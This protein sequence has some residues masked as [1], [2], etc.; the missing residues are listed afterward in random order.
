MPGIVVT[1]SQ[2]AKFLPDPD[3]IRQFEKLLAAVDSL[4]ETIDDRVALLIQDGTGISWVYDDSADT[5][6]PT[7]TLA[8][9]STTDLSE[10]TNLYYTEARV[11]ANTDVTANTSHRGSTSNP[12]SV[13]KAQVGLGNV[14]NT[15]DANKPVST[16]QQ[17][18]LDLKANIASPS[19]TGTAKTE[20]DTFG[21]DTAKT[22]SSASD[23]GTTGQIAWDSTYFYICVATDTWQ[24][25][26]H[27]TW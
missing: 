17:T 16:T 2:L 9:F 25:V 15:S 12:H 24:R 26:A 27:A 4:N 10:G 18:A 5:L 11:S 13:T 1:R 6:T 22:P 20:G 21:I 23:T 7:V 3:T 8:P 14:D 19:F